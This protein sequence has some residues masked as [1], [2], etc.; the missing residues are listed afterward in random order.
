LCAINYGEWFMA[1][2]GTRIRKLRDEQRMSQ[3]QLA[4]M[5]GV[6]LAS[7]SYYECDHRQPTLEK[8]ILFATIFGVTTDYLLLGDQLINSSIEKELLPLLR[9]LHELPPS[10]QNLA[11]RV[12][13]AILFHAPPI[14]TTLV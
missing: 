2:L 3:K 12:L 9:A 13:R 11:L 5:L 7:L 10:E 1:T 6:S 4:K 14:E 8:L